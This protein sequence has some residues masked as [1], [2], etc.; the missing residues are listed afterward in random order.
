MKR[1]ATIILTC[2]AVNFIGAQSTWENCSTEEFSKTIMAMEQ[3]VMD[4]SSYS[5]NTDYLFYDQADSPMPIMQETGL[6]IC[7]KGETI[8]IE[9]F[10]KTIIQNKNVQVE[11]DPVYHTIVL[12][13]PL[14]AYLKPQTASD[15]SALDMPGASVKK[16]MVGETK[17]FYISFPDGNL[18]VAAEVTTGGAMGITKYVLYAK[19]T[20]IENED[21]KPVQAQPRMEVTYKNFLKGDQAKT[22]Q[23]KHVADYVSQKGNVFAL[24]LDYQDYELIDLR[25]QPE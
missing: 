2:C 14:E 22:N 25:S 4:K 16:K 8:Y 10:G 6:L 15:F 23:M 3:A 21:G 24:N 13:D 5:Y 20:T 17:M 11:V 19:P 18:Y 9:Q 7:D 12:R 1:L